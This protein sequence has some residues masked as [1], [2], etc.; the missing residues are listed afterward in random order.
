MGKIFA[1]P[2]VALGALTILVLMAVGLAACGVTTTTHEGVSSAFTPAEMSYRITDISPGVVSVLALDIEK[3]K[4]DSY[5]HGGA[6]HEGIKKVE[7][8]YRIRFGI[9]IQYW[10][11][12]G[13][14]TKE[15]LLFVAPK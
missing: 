7:Q 6:L 13:A 12:E 14:W 8:R 9:P 15:I 5:G 10:E 11:A 4:D 3:E 2:K 1:W